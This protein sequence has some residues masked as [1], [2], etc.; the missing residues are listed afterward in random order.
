MILLV[1]LENL[2]LRKKDI[3]D[4]EDLANEV[5]FFISNV[6][7]GLYARPNRL[8]PKTERSK[9]RFKV[10]NYYKNLTKIS[11]ELKDGEGTTNLLI[12]LY[13]RLST[14]SIYLAFFSWNTFGALGIS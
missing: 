10:K 1:I 4:Y 9:W 2:L 7:D 3:I 5:L 12:M 11:L 6:D 14:G 8:I 13:V